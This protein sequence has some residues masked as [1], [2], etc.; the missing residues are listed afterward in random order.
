VSTMPGLVIGTPRY[1]SPEQV[2]GQDLDARSDV[3]SLGV[4]LYEMLAGAPPFDG[5]TPSDVMGAILLVDPRPLADRAPS[6]PPRAVAVVSRALQRDPVRRFPSAE[7][8]HRELLAA[9]EELE[10]TLPRRRGVRWIVTSAAVLAIAA[11]AALRW[12]PSEPAAPRSAS[13]AVLPFH[14]LDG[15]DDDHLGVGMA[16]TLITQ[17]GRVNRFVVRP[18]AAVLPLPAD[19]DPVKAGVDLKTDLVLAG[20]VQRSGGKLRVNVQLLD[21]G[22]RAPLWSE[23]F[24]EPFT[25]LFAVQDSI[26]QRVVD[27]LSLTLT[28]DERARLTRRSTSDPEAYQLYATGRYYW[29]RRTAVDI[30]KS[31]TYLNRAI[32]RD[33]RYAL[34][35][36]ALGDAYLSLGNYCYLAPRQAYP[37][38][39][40]AAARAIDLDPELAEPR[41]TRAYASY[42]FDW[43]PSTA[44]REFKVA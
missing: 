11:A 19:V 8:M 39:K 41:I 7:Q 30:E 22:R 38:A 29:N 1:M 15:P 4:I 10:V 6:A 32:A 44:D 27:S 5:A 24:D 12:V 37:Q 26:A 42:L 36:A 14:L 33:G 20:D 16:D 28:H 40:A 31:I 43:D 25:E 34:A 2:R 23:T 21:V 17:L 3:W 18:T 35:H 9:R 13:I